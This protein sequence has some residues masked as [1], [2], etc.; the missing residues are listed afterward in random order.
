MSNKVKYTIPKDLTPNPIPSSTDS[1][2]GGDWIDT[3]GGGCSRHLYK[4]FKNI[5]TCDVCLCALVRIRAHDEGWEAEFNRALFPLVP[6]I[7][8]R[9]REVL[10]ITV[11]N[12]LFSRMRSLKNPGGIDG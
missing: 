4:V 12:I 10:K 8:L 2:Y 5:K 6:N 11:D 1:F 7:I 9:S 3:A